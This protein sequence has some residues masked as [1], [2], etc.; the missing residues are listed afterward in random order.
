MVDVMYSIKEFKELFVLSIKA[1][2]P[3]SNKRVNT[4]SFMDRSVNN[5]KILQEGLPLILE[6]RAL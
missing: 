1:L 3:Y 4:P 6:I 2:S 5:F